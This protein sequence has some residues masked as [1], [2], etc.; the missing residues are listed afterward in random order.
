MNERDYFAD[1]ARPAGVQHTVRV[2]RLDWLPDLKTATHF[3]ASRDGL[4]NLWE[5]KP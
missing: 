2:N 5:R 1:M 4:A 3:R